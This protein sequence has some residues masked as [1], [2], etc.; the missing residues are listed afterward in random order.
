DLRF[1]RLAILALQE[2]AEAFLVGHF[3]LVNLLAIYAKRVTIQHKDL[4]LLNL[5]RGR[6][7]GQ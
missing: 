4:R 7:T 5:I 1:Q 6:L 2:A 3:E